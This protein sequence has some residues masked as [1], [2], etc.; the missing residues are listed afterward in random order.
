VTSVPKDDR[1]ILTVEETAR[2]IEAFLKGHGPATEEEMRPVVDW[3]TECKLGAAMLQ[4]VMRGEV[5]LDH[6]ER[7]VVL[8]LADHAKKR[9]AS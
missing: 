5:V 9:A 8:I 2:V 1:S 6:G 3:A 4:L 7:G